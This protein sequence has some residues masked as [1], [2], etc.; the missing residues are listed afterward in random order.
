MSTAVIVFELTSQLSYMLPVLI[1]VLTGKA[2]AGL[3]TRHYI[4]D[5]LAR[6]RNLPTLPRL[7]SRQACTTTIRKFV[8]TDLAKR[9]VCRRMNKDALYKLLKSKEALTGQPF[10]IVN[11]TQDPLYF[12]SISTKE[13][14]QAYKSLQDANGDIGKSEVDLTQFTDLDNSVPKLSCEASIHETLRLAFFRGQQQEF[15]VTERG[16]LY[17]CLLMEDLVKAADSGNL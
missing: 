17:G 7:K 12:G 2:V 10:A 15:F 4:Y 9:V 6:S 5:S 16:K 14:R 3:V 8:R 11:G 13:L 1:S